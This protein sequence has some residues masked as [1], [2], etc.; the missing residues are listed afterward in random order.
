MSS[1]ELK[2]NALGVMVEGNVYL[3]RR[4]MLDGARVV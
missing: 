1:S 3:R 4:V 2:W